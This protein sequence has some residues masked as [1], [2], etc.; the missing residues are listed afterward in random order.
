MS[1]QSPI[2][3]TGLHAADNPSPG[4]AVARCLAAAGRPVIGCCYSAIETGGHVPGVF[5]RVYR[6]SRP[7]DVGKDAFLARLAEIFAQSGA[8]AVIPTL[9][10]EIMIFAE[11]RERFEALGVRCLLASPESLE[12]T[13]KQTLAELGRKCGFRVP[14]LH[15]VSTLKEARRSAREIGLPLMVKGA[16]Y[17]AYRVDYQDEVPA[18]FRKL[19]K[20][21]GAPVLLQAQADGIEAVVACLC[22]RPGHLARS[23]SLRKLGMSDQ[24]TTWCGVTFRNEALI[25]GC[26]RLLAELE[27]LGPCEVEVLIDDRNGL[28]TLIEIN[29]RFPSWIAISEQLGTNMPY[30][31]VRVLEGESLGAD[32]GYP[33]GRAMVRQITDR[34]VQL[35]RLVQLDAGGS[36]DG[37]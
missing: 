14:K 10:P 1:P 17:E 11:H 5:D 8:R 33:A 20:K 27:W 34:V 19:R 6:L 29:S 30:D 24:G 22:D 23:L 28:M 37:C 12:R 32:P 18:L 35:S 31:L 9:E 21:W 26:R 36:V 13:R 3:V 15:P 25:E 4:V 2:A 7:Q 16:W